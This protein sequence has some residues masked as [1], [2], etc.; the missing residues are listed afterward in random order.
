MTQIKQQRIS[1]GTAIAGTHHR[2]S[3]FGG[4]AK[5]SRLLLLGAV[6]ALL[7][8]LFAILALSVIGNSSGV[9]G[10]GVGGA[11]AGLGP[12]AVAQSS[13]LG[14]NNNRPGGGSSNILPD[15]DG[16]SPNGKALASS[17]LLRRSPQ[18]QPPPILDEQEDAQLLP[19]DP[20][21]PPE[22]GGGGA[23]VA[24]SSN[25]IL[26]GRAMRRNFGGGGGDQQAVD[27][28]GAEAAGAD[29]GQQDDDEAAKDDDEE[30]AVDDQND[31]DIEAA[32]AAADDDDEANDDDPDDGRAEDGDV[33]GDEDGNNN[34][35]KAEAKRRN[36]VKPAGVQIVDD[37]DEK[38]LLEEEGDNGGDDY[39]ANVDGEVMGG[40]DGGEEA[41]AIFGRA[42]D[43]NYMEEETKDGKGALAPP[44]K[45]VRQQA[46]AEDGT[47]AEGDRPV[48]KAYIEEIDQEDWKIKP[49][50]VRRTTSS[51][52][53]VNEY[54]QV[55]S[56]RHLTE[57]FPIDEPPTDEDPFL[58]WIH[59]IFP[60]SDG[61]Y[62]QF[63][64]QN[65]RRCQSGTK[66]AKLKRFLQ[67]NVALFQHVP[68]KRIEDDAGIDGGDA[69]ETRYRL[70]THE[71]ADADAVATRFICRFSTGQETL[72][73]FNF[74][75]DYHTYRKMYKSTF[76]EEGFDNHMIWSSQHLF[77]CPVPDDLIETVK[78]GSSVVDDRATLFLDLVPIRTPPR[79]GYPTQF[80]QPK[81]QNVPKV[82]ADGEFEFDAEKEWGRQHILPR[83][84]DSGRWENLP[85]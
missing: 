4:G 60:T 68:V 71:D 3:S 66:F 67:P 32:A 37:D 38:A 82:G 13:S 28:G 22:G 77:K 29:D 44:T 69:S 48:L 70:S 85:M 81:Y 62:I 19:Q 26:G 12:E 55:T 64:A 17:S 18:K 34:D 59:D 21:A 8:G 6:M 65:R 54:K 76:T 25:K 16:L 75:Y 35:N 80:M 27:S 31:D 10:G 41:G 83:I 57:Q 1:K 39:Q 53:K 50:P 24:G 33:G 79:Y 56:C 5:C 40:G 49:L 51:T 61:R 15:G 2:P 30:G 84:S 20:A 9:G 42:D 11:G 74:D 52:L 43:Q 73:D 23:A 72:S 46:K 45:Q 7:Y 58:P 36:F 14:S 78:A 47:G 63:V